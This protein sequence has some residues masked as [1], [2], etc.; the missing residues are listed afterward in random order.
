VWLDLVQ[1]AK[2]GE[3]PIEVNW[4]PFS[5]DQINQKVGDDYL[6]WNEAEENIPD[7]LW[8]LRASVA[9]GRQGDDAMR[10]FFPLLLRARHEDR[11]NIGD[12]DVLKETATAA[13]LDV[14]RFERDVK[15]RSTLDEVAKSH[16]EG[17]EQ[18][19]VFGTPTFV[20]E[21]G[22]SA[23]LKL[24]RPNT[25][26]DALAAFDNVLGVMQSCTY[27]GEIKRPQPPWP[28]GVL[29]R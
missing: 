26:E 4:K 2:G 1:E 22:T 23:F 21:D 25:P 6:V 17:V 7:R 10:R 3:A 12:M 9:A 24:I 16:A 29:G 11:K 18:H 8:G 5:L 13:G 15:D 27:V 28:K 20:F 14:E 19:G